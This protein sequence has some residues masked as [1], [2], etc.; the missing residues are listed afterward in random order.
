MVLPAPLIAA[1]HSFALLGVAA[2]SVAPRLRSLRDVMRNIGCDAQYRGLFLPTSSCLGTATLLAFTMAHLA[3]QEL[4]SQHG[5]LAHTHPALVR[6]LCHATQRFGGPSSTVGHHALVT[7]TH[8]RYECMLALA[9]SK[10]SSYS[11]F[12]RMHGACV[13]L[14][15]GVGAASWAACMDNARIRTASPVSVCLVCDACNCVG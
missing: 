7:T 4:Y 8:G 13:F 5:A 14:L 15:G 11:L 6:T 12:W 2:M 3:V 9:C 1:L 10:C